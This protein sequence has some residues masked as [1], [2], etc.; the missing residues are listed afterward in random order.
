MYTTDAKIMCVRAYMRLKSLRK[1]AGLLGVA[2]S[3]I[4]RWIAS[5]PLPRKIR[6]ARKATQSAVKRILEVLETN[7]F[8]TPEAIC[9]KIRIELG[10][11]LGTSTVRFWMKKNGL[12]RK[13]ASRLVSND[14]IHELRKSYSKNL[15]ALYD[16]DRVIS[17]DESSFYFDMKPSRGYCN[18]SR[19][20]VV[21][22]RPGGRTRWS[23]LMAVSN[24]SVVGWKLFKG[25]VNSSMFSAFIE[26]LD[27]EERDVLLMDNAS[28]HK[29]R[30]V[31]DTI[32]SRG[33][34]PCYLPPYTP[35]FQPIEHSFSVIK[36]KYRSIHDAT[37]IVSNSAMEERVRQAVSVITS[38]SLYHQFE[39]CWKRT[40]A[41][42]D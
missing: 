39:A 29:T 15:A 6:E 37:N 41:F 16:P 9:F 26:T 23:L 19:R 18:R 12:S 38:S 25:S 5:N 20:L 28:I 27:T 7:P 30:L 3:T 36:T 31:Q 8:E 21:P 13:K 4:H 1:T 22:A 2:K 10:I 14:R 17:I 40:H 24:N 11:S 34:T 33:M 42:M 35:E 32:V